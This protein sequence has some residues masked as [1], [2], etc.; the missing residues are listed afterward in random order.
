MKEKVWV[1]QPEG[2]EETR[3]ENLALLLLKVLYGTKQGGR[4]EWHKTL[5]EFMV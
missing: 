1:T 3:K 2:F 5:F 4:N